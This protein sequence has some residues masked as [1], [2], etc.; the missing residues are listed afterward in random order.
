MTT[1]RAKVSFRFKELGA[2][3]ALSVEQSSSGDAD[4]LPGNIYFEL[5]PGTTIKDVQKIAAYLNENM[6]D[7]VRIFS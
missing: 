6:E 3:P 5:R 7:I 4:I 1:H 2:D